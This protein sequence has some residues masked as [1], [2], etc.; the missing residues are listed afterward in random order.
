MGD[1]KSWRELLDRM[2]PMM[3]LRLAL[4]VVAA[5]LPITLAVMLR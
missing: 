5:I 3:W 2:T 1:P 4:L